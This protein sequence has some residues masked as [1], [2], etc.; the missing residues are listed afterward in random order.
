VE[1]ACLFSCDSDNTVTLH[2]TLSPTLTGCFWIRVSQSLERVDSELTG[3]LHHCTGA[4]ARAGTGVRTVYSASRNEFA[5]KTLA[6]GRCAEK[7]TGQLEH[8]SAETSPHCAIQ[9]PVAS[10]CAHALRCVCCTLCQNSN[11]RRSLAHSATLRSSFS[12]LH[13]TRQKMSEEAE[14]AE[15]KRLKKE[16]KA[17]EAAAATGTADTAAPMESDS[18]D[19]EQRGA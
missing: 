3:L 13:S 7:K 6:F 11:S 8:N 19:A 14:R 10:E 5:V 17:K 15:R 12:P 16:K 9:A 2:L 1:H 18:A 4:A